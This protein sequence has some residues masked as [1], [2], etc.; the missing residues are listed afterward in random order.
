M[1]S[2]YRRGKTWW[3][4]YLV[5]GKRKQQ[6]LRTTNERVAR[7]RKKQ[8]EALG[9]VNQL[10]EPSSTP[11]IPLLE[12]FCRHLKATG[13][14]ESAKTD[15]S[16]L[17]GF[18]GPCSLSLRLP[19]RTPRKH[20]VEPTDAPELEN[21]GNGMRLRITKLE[22]LTPLIVNNDLAERVAEGDIQPKTANHYRELL[23]RLFK[24]AAEHH[25]Y[26]CPDVR[27]RNPIEGVTRWKESAPEIRWLTLDQIAMQL[28]AVEQH[29]T[30]HALV[31]TYIYAGLRRAEAL[32]LA[33]SDVDLDQRLIRVRAKTV[34]GES[35]QPKTKRNR[36][37]PISTSLATILKRYTAERSRS[38][39]FFPAP[40]GGRWQP[41]N[42][43]HDLAALNRAAGLEWACLDFR[44]TFGSH[45]AQR[46]VSLYK[47][48]QLMGN[49][50]EICRRHYAALV[51]EAMHNEVEFGEVQVSSLRPEPVEPV[52]AY[53]TS[54]SPEEVRPRLRLV[55]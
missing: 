28:G 22:Q 52:A 16:R 41:D 34:D 21:P 39:W 55:R 47:I 23:H 3:I 35:W 14:R 26:V 18:F 8:Y 53:A 9:T 49:S 37:V 29:L 40:Q 11:I 30:I 6:S 45:L 38:R 33:C 36:V 42:F 32:W 4:E 17:R 10:P 12:S 2:I 50:P 27:Y 43:S 48:S 46:G 20:R 1:A 19:P 15:I 54:R 5:N 31:A 13:T 7:D 51:P 44:H 25:G 24:Y